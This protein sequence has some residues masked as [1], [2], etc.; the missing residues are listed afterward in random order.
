MYEVELSKQNISFPLPLHIGF[1]VYGYARLFML[2]FYFDFLDHFFSCQ[3]FCLIET[4]TDSFYL[5]F[6]AKNLEDIVKPDLKEELRQNVYHWLPAPTCPAHRHLHDGG[7][8]ITCCQQFYLYDKKTPGKFKLEFEGDKTIALRSK[9]Y[10]VSSI[11]TGQNKLSSKGYLTN[12]TISSSK[13]TST[14][15]YPKSRNEDKTL[16]SG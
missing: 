8:G 9:S 10:I 5:D 12:N 14:P 4:D 3:D 15:C 16:G 11:E 1:F 6:S 13:T 2:K 7:D